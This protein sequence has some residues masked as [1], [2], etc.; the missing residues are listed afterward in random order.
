MELVPWWITRIGKVE[1]SSVA[2]SIRS[3]HISQGPVTEELE[4]RMAE[5]LDVPYVLA[6]TSCSVALLMA[7]MALGIK[8]DDEVIVPNRTWIATAHAPLILGAKVVL[9]DV[10]PELPIMDVSSVK[11]SITGRTRAIMPVHLCGRSVDMEAVGEIARENG[12]YVIEDAAQALFSRNSR[13]F[14]GTQSNVGCF[15]LGMTKLIS[16]GQGGIVVTRDRE[17]YEKIKKIRNHGVTNNFY[18]V[19]S[20][21]GCN[22]RI[23]DLQASLGIP[24]LSRLKKRLAHIKSIYERYAD[25][26]KELPYLKIIPVAVSHGEIPIYVEVMSNERKKLIDFLTSRGIEIR[27]FLP[28]LCSAPYL[29]CNDD[30]PN[31]KAFNDQG[32]FLPCGPDQPMR[33]VDRVI[34]TLHLYGK[35]EK[36]SEKN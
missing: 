10:T 21:V 35:K 19:F 8:K 12:L 27:P 5:L 20:Q 16:T 33:N 30:F 14:L 2:E 22:F 11:K 9:V 29:E 6:T 34:E 32:L 25:G 1:I 17:I 4:A 28:N 26:I 3:G 23:T 7:L 24:Q 31:S 18:P 15:S 36:G 13:G